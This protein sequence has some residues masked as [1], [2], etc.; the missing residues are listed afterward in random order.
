MLGKERQV[1]QLVRAA[2]LY[3]GSQVRVLSCRQ[4]NKATLRVFFRV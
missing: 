4:V 2:V 3:A 1:A